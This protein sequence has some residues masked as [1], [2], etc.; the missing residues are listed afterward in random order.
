MWKENVDALRTL[1]GCGMGEGGGREAANAVLKI[2][3][4]F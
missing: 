3:K 1:N 2:K 4:S